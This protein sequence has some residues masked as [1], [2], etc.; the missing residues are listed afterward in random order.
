MKGNGDNTI[1]DHYP[2][3]CYQETGITKSVRWYRSKFYE[4]EFDESCCC[5]LFAYALSN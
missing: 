2:E 5:G 3:K 1:P 4:L